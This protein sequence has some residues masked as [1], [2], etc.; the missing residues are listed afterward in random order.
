MLKI[1]RTENLTTS[2][3]RDSKDKRGLT[4]SAAPSPLAD[5]SCSLLMVV[6]LNGYRD[7]GREVQQATMHPNHMCWSVF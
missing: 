5:N 3:E 7:W 2:E 1:K 4:D 6:R